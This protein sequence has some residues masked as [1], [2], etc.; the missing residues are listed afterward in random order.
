MRSNKNINL[1][2]QFDFTDILS[3]KIQENVVNSMEKLF[4]DN[5]S[6]NLNNVHLD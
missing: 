4:F 6:L 5:E 2:I 1:G 3:S